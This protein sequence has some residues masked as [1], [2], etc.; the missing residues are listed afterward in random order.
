LGT[1]QKERSTSA[2]AGVIGKEKRREGDGEEEN[3]K[4]IVKGRGR[5]DLPISVPKD[6][7]RELG[8]VEFW[9]INGRKGGK[10]NRPPSRSPSYAKKDE[11]H[12]SFH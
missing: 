5:S 2:L 11:S 10:K 7:D 12:G 6:H 3:R 9:S 4:G 1:L 8:N